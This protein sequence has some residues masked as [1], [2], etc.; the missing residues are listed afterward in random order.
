MQTIIKSSRLAAISML[1]TSAAGA[2]PY[3]SLGRVE[4]RCWPASFATSLVKS[5]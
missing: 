4:D 3:T 2:A 5:L 1:S